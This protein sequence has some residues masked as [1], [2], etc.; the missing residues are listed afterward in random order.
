MILLLY[1]LTFF[2]ALILSYGKYHKIFN[3]ITLFTGMWCFWGVISIF[4]PLNLIIPDT[5]VHKYIIMF[6]MTVDVV[7]IFFSKTNNPN[8]TEEIN[9]KNVSVIQAISIILIIPI[10]LK[11]IPLLISGGPTA[12][13]EQYFKENNFGSIFGDMLF[14]NMPM[15][16]LNSLTIIYVYI[17]FKTKNYKYLIYALI[18]TVIVT[19]L[20]GGRY[21]IIQV[22]YILLIFATSNTKEFVLG[23]KPYKSKIKK[24]GILIIVFMILITASRKQS[25]FDSTITYYSG[26]LSF[27]EYIIR[28]P[29]MFGLDN[30]LYG[31]LTF[32]AIVEPIILLGKVLGLTAIKIPSYEFNILCQE[33]YNI[34]QHGTTLINANTTI[35]Y[36]FLRDFGQYG[37]LLGGFFIGVLTTFAYN[38]W[39]KGSNFFGLLYGYFGVCLLNS[40]MTYQFFGQAPFFIIFVFYICT[41]KPKNKI[42]I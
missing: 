4:G 40:I 42:L 28:H 39:Q 1:I 12:V 16:F 35:I 8:S 17:S 29:H 11:F 9:Y 3:L 14:R 23:L 27:L 26:S 36:Y 31:Y 22:L 21:A 15:A 25:I 6:V 19:T 24:I 33:Y 18:N 7:M 2:I 38:K 37:I 13:R 20:N 30:K 5:T 41:T 10:A 34:A 32:G